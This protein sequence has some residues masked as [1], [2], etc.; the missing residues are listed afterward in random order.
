MSLTENI[1]KIFSAENLE[2]LL[3]TKIKL[4]LNQVSIESWLDNH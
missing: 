1:L 2:A 3:L 4:V